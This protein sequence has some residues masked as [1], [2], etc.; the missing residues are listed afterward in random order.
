MEEENDYSESVVEED[1]INPQRK[2]EN[3]EIGTIV[4]AVE[5]DSQAL[6]T[7]SNKIKSAFEKFGKVANYG[8]EYR[9]WIQ[10]DMGEVIKKYRK[11]GRALASSPNDL[12]EDFKSFIAKNANSGRGL[13]YSA[14]AG[15][16]KNCEK[17]PHR[18]EELA[19]LVAEWWIAKQTGDRTTPLAKKMQQPVQN[20]DW[21]NLSK[22]WR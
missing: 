19:D 13:R 15:W 22:S 6:D 1:L 5:N 2:I 21:M 3:H 11:S 12:N 4:P 16:V 14:V 10:N 9:D 18:W 17:D 8:S 20:L 7:H